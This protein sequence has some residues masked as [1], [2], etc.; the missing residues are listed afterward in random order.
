M[1]ARGSAGSDAGDGEFQR[2]AVEY[3]DDPADRANEA[4]AVET[5][6]GHRARPG[7]VMHGAW[8]DLDQHLLRSSAQLD[9]FCG[10][11][12]A[13]GGLDQIKVVDVDALL[14]SEA[15]CRACR[16][17]DGV[18]SHGL[19]RT[20]YFDF[21]VSLLGAQSPDPGSQAAWRAEGLHRHT[22]K[23]VLGGEEFLDVGAELC[24]GLR[25]HPRGDLFAAD[26]EQE[27]DALVFRVCLHARTSRCAAV[28]PICDKYDAAV[29]QARVRTRAMSAARS[30]VEITPRA[31]IRLN[32]CEHLR[33]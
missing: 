23:Q 28:P 22:V 8:Q 21:N 25:K 31:S 30:V 16:R 24:F 3:G 19:G 32:S 27:F 6:P 5:G 14:F 33:Q 2:F 13:L 29:R 10:Q 4:C 12:F 26:F 15:L 17:A 18:V 20:A 11:V 7:Q 1:A 9:L